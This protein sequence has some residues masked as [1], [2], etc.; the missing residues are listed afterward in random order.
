VS[1][2]QAVA[3]PL[4]GSERAHAE[5]RRSANEFPRKVRPLILGLRSDGCTWEQTAAELNARGITTPKGRS[6]T[7]AN[8][9]EFVKARNWKSPPAKRQSRRD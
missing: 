7:L 1:I 3:T 9:E 6:W 8:V 2:L 4:E 5:Q